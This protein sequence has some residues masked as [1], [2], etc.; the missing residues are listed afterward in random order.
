MLQLLSLRSDYR[1][2]KI[3]LWLLHPIP[4]II[5]LNRTIIPQMRL[6]YDQFITVFSIRNFATSKWSLTF[7]KIKWRSIRICLNY[8]TFCC[9][10]HLQRSI[11][12]SQLLRNY[13]SFFWPIFLTALSLDSFL[14][15]VLKIM[16]KHNFFLALNRKKKL[17]LIEK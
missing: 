5:G 14:L 16:S 3:T 6:Y 2:I 1:T 4:N 13:N 12:M 7:I 15:W 8:Y 10:Q 9:R 11:V 17:I